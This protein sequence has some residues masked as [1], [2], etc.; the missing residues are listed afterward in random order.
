[1]N[2]IDILVLIQ[3]AKFVGIDNL[4]LG[5]A[6][7]MTYCLLGLLVSGAPLYMVVLLG[8][9]KPNNPELS[10]NDYPFLFRRKPAVV[11]RLNCA[12]MVRSQKTVVRLNWK[13]I[14]N[15]E[16]RRRKYVVYKL[17]IKDEFNVTLVGETFASFLTDENYIF[18]H[19]PIYW[20][21]CEEYPS[22]IP[23]T[24]NHVSPS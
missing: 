6:G 2:E 19:H 22:D 5:S 3:V 18:D 11:I 14:P 20:V 9:L 8:K 12:L 13:D 23:R 16:R 17:T 15:P 10:A 21:E 24:S 1:M 7:P 4:I